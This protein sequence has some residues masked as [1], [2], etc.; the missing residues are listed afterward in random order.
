MF[1]EIKSSACRIVINC[2]LDDQIESPTD[3]SHFDPI[4]LAL[5]PPTDRGR[6]DARTDGRKSAAACAPQQQQQQRGG[7]EQEQ[8]ATA[9]TAVGSCDGR[10]F[11][12]RRRRRSPLSY[13]QSVSHS[14]RPPPSLPACQPGRGDRRRRRRPACRA[15]TTSPRIFAVGIHS[16]SLSKTLPKV[17]RIFS[18]ELNA[19]RGLTQLSRSE[20]AVGAT[21]TAEQD[22]IERRHQA[23]LEQRLSSPLLSNGGTHDDGDDPRNKETS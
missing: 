20:A 22:I 2:Q 4:C 7:E 5:A 18:P 6:V 23:T 13:P 11:R 14:I 12:R 19:P 17:R 1:A 15:V 10:D 9:A 3:F 21:P 16:C 8:E